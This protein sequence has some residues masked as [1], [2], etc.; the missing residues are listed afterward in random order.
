MLPLC[1]INFFWFFFFLFL[2]ILPPVGSYVVVKGKEDKIVA[3]VVKVIALRHYYS[4]EICE[5]KKSNVVLQNEHGST[6]SLCVFEC[7][8]VNITELDASAVHGYLV[9]EAMS[10]KEERMQTHQ[11]SVVFHSKTLFLQKS[12]IFLN[13][14]SLVVLSERVV[15][16][17][18][19]KSEFLANF[20]LVHEIS[21][22]FCF[23][24]IKF[25]LICRKR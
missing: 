6:E 9:I 17:E 7:V 20:F 22:F 14:T 16:F 18:Q 4:W 25:G 5:V 15:F 19:V 2:Q 11:H 10:N 8:P 21:F 13:P 23:H 12:A 3:K 1:L 24:F